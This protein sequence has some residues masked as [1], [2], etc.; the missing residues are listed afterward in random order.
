MAPA[1]ARKDFFILKMPP[2]SLAKASR[3]RD[4]QAYFWAAGALSDY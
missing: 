3:Y 4:A 2:H 1:Y